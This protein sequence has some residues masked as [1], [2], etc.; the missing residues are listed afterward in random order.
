MKKLFVAWIMILLTGCAASSYQ[1]LQND[2]AVKD[3]FVIDRNYQAVYRD[4]LSAARQQ[5][6][7]ALMGG[8]MNVN[9]QLYTDI[10][11][12]E[13]DI[14]ISGM[15]GSKIYGGVTITALSD[16]RSEVTSYAALSTWSD[17]PDY[18]R[19]WANYSQ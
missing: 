15:A 5:Y 16:Q 11:T 6:Q 4:V 18:V 2:P 1:A 7:G 13:I 10:K 19:R 17:F 12:G 9:G 3:Q 14:S 8:S